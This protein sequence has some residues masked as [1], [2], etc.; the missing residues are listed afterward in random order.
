MNDHRRERYQL[1]VCTSI[2]VLCCSVS[3]IMSSIL[4]LHLYTYENSNREKDIHEVSYCVKF[5]AIP[6]HV[7]MYALL[8]Y[9]VNLKQLSVSQYFK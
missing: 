8:M 4:S 1:S 7:C 5:E 2:M 3:L 6:L 9:I